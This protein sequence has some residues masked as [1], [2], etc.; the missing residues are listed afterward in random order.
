M[1]SLK[2]WSHTKFGAISKEINK[3]RKRMEELIIQNPSKDQPELIDLRN[4]MEELL[5]H[6]EIML[7]QRSRISWL[8]EG[9]R[10]TKYFHRKAAGRAKKN[11]IKSLRK[12]DGQVTKQKD[13]METMA[14]DFFK[15][16]YMADP[17][18]QAQEV[19]NLMQL[20][21]TDEI[22]EALCKDFSDKEISDAMFWIGP[23]KAPG[24]DGFP[25]WF[26]QRH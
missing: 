17:M 23:L 10:N 19:L 12:T 24:P 13:E 15:E 9:D 26:F 21:I 25:A 16:L 14:C 8:R 3:I 2:K 11:K 1:F 20:K 6:E 5:H 7:L 4:R 18:V 22:N